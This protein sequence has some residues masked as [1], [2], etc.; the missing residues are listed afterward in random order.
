P[1]A[2][3]GDD[4]IDLSIDEFEEENEKVPLKFEKRKAGKARNMVVEMDH[5]KLGKIQ[6]VA[7]PIKYSRT[8]LKIRSFAPKIGQ[9]TKEVLRSLGYSDDKIRDLKKKGIM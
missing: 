3:K 8:P 5:P 2:I 9:N 1:A 6:N 7:S 4:E